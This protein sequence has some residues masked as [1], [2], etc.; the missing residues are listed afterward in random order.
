MISRQWQSCLTDDERRAILKLDARTS[1]LD[2]IRAQLAV[3]R[4]LIQ[5]RATQRAARKAR[6][7]NAQD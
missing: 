2:R 4:N 7:S 5:N 1:T 6:K 3:E